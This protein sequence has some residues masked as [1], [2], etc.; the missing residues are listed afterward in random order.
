M[1]HIT[2]PQKAAKRSTI[3]MATTCMHRYRKPCNHFFMVNMVSGAD[4]RHVSPTMKK[5]PHFPT[6]Q[7]YPN[8]HLSNKVSVDL[9][10]V[11]ISLAWVQAI[12][13][14]NQLPWSQ[15]LSFTLYWQILRRESVLI[16]VFIGTKCWEPRKD[17]ALRSA[18]RSAPQISKWKKIILKESLWDQGS[19]QPGFFESQLALTQ[20]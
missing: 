9:Y 15:R 20:G 17:L 1:F 4:C 3:T 12:S 19:N 13:T 2:N 18:L 14:C 16:F 11:A 6:W 10:H 8:W 5:K 7:P